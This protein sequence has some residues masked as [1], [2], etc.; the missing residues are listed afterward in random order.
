MKKPLLLISL[1]LG[2]L[3]NSEAKVQYEPVVIKFGI[4]IKKINP[5]YKNNTFYAEFYW[6]LIL[7]NDS[8]KTGLGNSEILSLE[9]T[10]SFGESVGSFNEEIIE[11]RNIDSNKFYYSGYHH[12]NFFFNCD[13]RQYPFDKQVLPILIE[14]NLL[15]SNQLLI[16]PDTN[17]YVRSKMEKSLWGVSKNLLENSRVNFGIN[18]T[19]IFSVDNTYNTDFG[20]LD[21]PPNSTFSLLSHK[22][23]ID[24]N[25]I[26]YITKLFIPLMII[27]LLV[28][29]VFFIPADKLDMAAGLTV[30]SLLSAIAFQFSVNSDLP[31]IGYLIYID[32]VFYTTYL[33]IVLAKAVS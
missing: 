2:F 18:S 15:T 14:S 6:W 28:Y 21:Y 7:E 11:S 16:L 17:S 32:K 4:H 22:I 10:N 26:P 27:L 12:G 25:I 24:R 8:Q 5:E 31:E 20:D 3:I 9:Y 19:Q 1:I 23:F 30:T 29:F 33:L 13:F